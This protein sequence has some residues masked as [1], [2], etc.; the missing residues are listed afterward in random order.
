[1]SDR[2]VIYE[3]GAEEEARR[4]WYL[5]S[6]DRFLAQLAHDL[7]TELSPGK[8]RV[9][10]AGCGTGGLLR[11]LQESGVNVVG[12]DSDEES[13][14]WGKR[15]GRLSRILRADVGHL[16][17][18][19]NTFDLSISSETLEHVKDDAKALDELLRV[20]RRYVLVTVPTHSYLWTD[21]DEILLHFRRYSR[22]DLQQLVLKSHGA[23]LKLRQYGFLPGLGVLF[24]KV[25]SP[26]FGIGGSKQADT[27]TLPLACRFKIPRM[28]DRCLGLAFQAELT[29]S[30]RGLLPWG[31][32]WWALI[33]KDA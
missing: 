1:M 16:P 15:Q 23:L 3:P 18:S 2:T 11:I 17:F 29:L 27:G 33:R 5:N 28:L 24:Y 12:L 31:H 9:L 26:L 13:L 19:D 8:P 4:G 7:I 25:A 21:S 30:R 14:R 20:S 10:D 6:R 32:G 22:N